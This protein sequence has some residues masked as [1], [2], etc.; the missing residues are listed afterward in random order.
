MEGHGVELAPGLHRIEAPLGERI[1]ACYLIVGAH[2]AL[3][4]DTGVDGTPAGSLLPYCESIGLK[5]ARVRWI[6]VSHC[7][8]DHMGGDASARARFPEAALVAHIAD[9]ALIEDVGRIVEE[10]YREFAVP[11]GIDIDAETVAW[12]H[13]VARAAPVD[14]VIGETVTIDLGARPV[15]VLPTPGHSPGSLSVHDPTSGAVMSSDAVLGR[16][17]HLRDGRPAFPPTYRLVAP[18]RATIA[19]LESLR[20]TWLLTAHEPAMDAAAGL[21]FLGASRGFADDLEA[22]MLAELDGVGHPLTLRELIERLAPRVGEWDPSTW[23][24]LAHPLAGHL[25]EAVTA[26]RLVLEPGPPARWTSTAA[27]GVGMTE[28]HAVGEGR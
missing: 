21:A 11:H 14:L 1:V 4:V 28:D 10:R 2:S 22:G 27:R 3:L 5:P 25:E 18:Y 6:V 19:A 26:G 9:R 15:V 24:L 23:D 8:V 16:S 17:L 20:P 12:C 13:A 7:D